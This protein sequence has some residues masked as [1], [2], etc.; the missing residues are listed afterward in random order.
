MRTTI[1]RWGAV[2]ASVGY[3]VTLASC[4]DRPAQ[5]MD[6]LDDAGCRISLDSPAIGTV[7]A[8]VA[9][10][11]FRFQPSEIRIPRGTR[12]TWLYCEPA[13]LDPH[14]TTS[15]T[16]LWDAEFTSSAD[17]FSH[18]FDQVG[19]FEYHCIPHAA[20]MRGVVIVE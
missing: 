19:R 16:G 15:D 7:G 10:R 13:G 14:T 6:P 11:D 1:Q 5:V 3:L 17:T 12:V 18:V 8:I 2:L 4:S 9:M 20:F